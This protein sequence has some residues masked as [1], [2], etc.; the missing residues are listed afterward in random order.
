MGK[1]REI[2]S[3]KQERTKQKV[4]ETERDKK[5]TGIDKL[6]KLE[7]AEEVCRGRYGV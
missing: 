6:R 5:D 1:K 7:K 3:L 4:R 2:P